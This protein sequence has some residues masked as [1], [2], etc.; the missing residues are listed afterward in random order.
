MLLSVSLTLIVVIVL[1]SSSYSYNVSGYY[2]ILVAL[3]ISYFSYGSG[4]IL[5]LSNVVQFGT[6]QLRDAPTRYSVYFICAYYWTDSFGQLLT[7]ATNIPGHEIVI[8]QQ[9]NAIALDSLKGSL[10]SSILS[11]SIVL[12]TV[13]LYIVYKKKSTRFIF[14]KCKQNPSNVFCS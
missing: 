11:L 13:L 12:S 4:Q 3:F 6:D 5:F 10:I 14:E 7:A 9:N 1:K 2:M 8:N